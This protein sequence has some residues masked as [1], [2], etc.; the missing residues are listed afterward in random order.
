VNLSVE[1]RATD[2]NDSVSGTSGYGMSDNDILNGMAGDDYL[3]GSTGDDTYIFSPG[4]D[5]VYDSSGTDTILFWE[6]WT[7]GDISIF[8][9]DDGLHYNVGDVVLKDTNGNAMVLSDYFDPWSPVRVEYVVFAD[10]TTWNLSSMDIEIWGTSGNDNL[11]A[12]DAFDL[13]MRGFDG[14]DYLGTYTYNDTLDGGDGDDT[15]VGNAGNDTYIYNAGLDTISDSSGTDTLFVKGATV[16]DLSFGVVNTFDLKITLN[17][18]TNEVTIDD[19]LGSYVVET[20][21]F[22]DGFSV[23]LTT[24]ASW[25]NGTSSGETLNGTSGADVLIGF[26][27]NDTINAGAS[28]DNAHGGSGNDTIYGDGGNDLVH[29]GI[30]NDTLYGGDGADLLYGD[31]GTDSLTGG[32]GDDRF[33]FMA[34]T[35]FANADTV[36]DF[37]ISSQEDVIDISDVL[38]GTGYQHGVDAV[39]DWVQITTSGSDSVVK[40]DVTGTGTFGTGTQIA[41]LTG[42]TGLT[43][44]AA[45]VSSGNLLMAA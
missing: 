37:N 12:S 18:G 20:L 17:T 26:A 2:G 25:I 42:I 45:L 41:T 3:A 6:G 15:L 11:S 5:I 10:S 24:Y 7:P 32:N 39:T 28:N 36:T 30:G 34:D 40:V 33:V 21:A 4:I 9:G 23:D 29:G 22:D 1:I 13:V 31:A 44:E 43:D 14:D 38:D 8:R 27:G 35:A 16:N 19:Q